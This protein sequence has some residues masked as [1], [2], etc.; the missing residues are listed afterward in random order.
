MLYELLTNCIPADVIIQT[1]TREFMKVLDDTLKHEVAHWAAY[2]EHRIRYSLTHSS[3]HSLTHLT[4][5]SLTQTWLQGN[6]SFGSIFSKIHG[7]I[8]EVVSADVHVIACL[9]DSR[10]DSCVSEWPLGIT[11]A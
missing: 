8:Q 1:L 11:R 10:D 5:Y 2:Y 4:T 9:A 7:Y 6:L 3:T